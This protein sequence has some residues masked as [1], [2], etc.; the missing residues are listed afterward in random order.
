MNNIFAIIAVSVFG[1][2]SLFSFYEYESNKILR[3]DIQEYE[4]EISKLEQQAE[5]QA[6]NYDIARR[7]ADEQMQE[8]RD[9]EQ[10][11]LATVVPGGCEEAIKWGLNEANTFN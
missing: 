6:K 3:I 7:E 9:N 4:T 11:I 1:I 2:L 10:I 5:Q 8:I